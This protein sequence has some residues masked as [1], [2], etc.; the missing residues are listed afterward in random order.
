MNKNP[1]PDPVNDPVTSIEVIE[2]I[3]EGAAYEEALQNALKKG[4]PMAYQVAEQEAGDMQAHPAEQYIGQT[5]ISIYKTVYALCAEWREEN[6]RS[7]EQDEEL[8]KAGIL[9]D[10]WNEVPEERMRPC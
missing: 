1:D 4:N 8:R 9:A 3:I 2:Q 6:E 7:N 5:S 10:P